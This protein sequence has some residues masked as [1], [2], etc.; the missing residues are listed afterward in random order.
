MLMLDMI[1]QKNE[2]QFGLA[3]IKSGAMSDIAES[4]SYY[5]RE[6]ETMH[7]R[8]D[9]VLF[10]AIPESAQAIRNAAIHAPSSN[11]FAAVLLALKSS[12]KS[13]DEIDISMMTGLSMSY[14][15]S[16]IRV[17]SHNQLILTLKNGKYRLDSRAE[18]PHNTIVSV[19]FKLNDWRKAL[20]QS[21]RHRA[22][23][24]KAFV[25][26]PINKKDLLKNN[27]DT[28]AEYG[29]SVGVFDAELGVYE[30][31]YEAKETKLSK[32]SYIDVL[33]RFWINEDSVFQL[34]A[35]PA[36]E[37]DASSVVI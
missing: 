28:F 21:I 33:S 20:K 12:R 29:V 34:D 37:L 8:P 5:I 32:L 22:F 3:F 10:D 7:G 23:A 2:E 24:D 27:L 26:M 4:S 9:L 25:I 17:L 13:L 35:N 19:E 14:V 31:I 16:T 11:A 30:T 15:G 6:L 1:K 36:F 18:I